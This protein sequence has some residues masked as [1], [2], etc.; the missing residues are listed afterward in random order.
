MHF[1]F[2][3]LDYEFNLPTF[4]QGIK[5]II[6]GLYLLKM[7]GF[8]LFGILLVYIGI[9][10]VLVIHE[11]TE[12]IF[13]VLF[14]EFT[15]NLLFMANK[16]G[17]KSVTW[18]LLLF[19]LLLVLIIYIARLIKYFSQEEKNILFLSFVFFA[20]ALVTEFVNTQSHIPVNIYHQLIALEEG[21][22][23]IAVTNLLRLKKDNI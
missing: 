9:D 11:K 19:P 6:I 22:E 16:L 5:A 21:C 13:R 10:E 23:L 12:N 15:S 17:Y 7:V 2:V 14:P 4:Y 18:I 3:N 1:S 20:I 8:K